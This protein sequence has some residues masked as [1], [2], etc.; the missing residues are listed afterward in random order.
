MDI[1]AQPVVGM[2]LIAAMPLWIMAPA[3]YIDS[4]GPDSLLRPPR[5]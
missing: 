1:P 3:D 2:S 4:I 5:A